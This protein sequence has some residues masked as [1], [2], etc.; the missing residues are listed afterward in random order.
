MGEAL[1]HNPYVSQTLVPAS[2]HV[3][4][5]VDS[6]REIPVFD[7]IIVWTYAVQYVIP[8]GSRIGREDMQRIK[9]ASS[10]LRE[11]IE[12]YT[13]LQGWPVFNFALS[14]EMTRLG[15]SVMKMSVATSALP[16]RNPDEIP[17][18]LGKHSF[19]VIAE[20]LTKR[21]VT[22]HHGFDLNFLPAKTRETDYSSTKNLSM[23]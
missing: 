18:F 10:E 5:L 4:N 22:V 2:R 20:L 7:L 17:F 6:L 9:S 1:A 8:P 3:F 23:G 21:Y 13:F 19:L 16:H 12:K 15:L 11:V 14:R